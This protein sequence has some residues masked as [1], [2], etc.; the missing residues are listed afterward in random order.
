VLHKTL[1]PQ[2]PRNDGY[3]M[4]AVFGAGKVD[5]RTRGGSQMWAPAVAGLTY[6]CC[7]GGAEESAWRERLHT[8]P[9]SSEAPTG[10]T[11]FPFRPT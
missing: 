3:R 7:E 4:L 5:V 9:R 2:R 8:S 11:F 1:R 10:H 6:V